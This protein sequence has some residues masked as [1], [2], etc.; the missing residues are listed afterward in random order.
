MAGQ[1]AGKIARFFGTNPFFIETK[2]D[3]GFGFWNEPI[4]YYSI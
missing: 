1:K 3:D 2:G 4:F